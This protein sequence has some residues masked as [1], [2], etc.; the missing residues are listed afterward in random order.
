MSS[1]EL[2]FK[3]MVS[4]SANEVENF[5]DFAEDRAIIWAANEIKKFATALERI[6]ALDCV[7]GVGCVVNDKCECP[8]CIAADALKARAAGGGGDD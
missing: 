1:A 7:Y 5:N 3:E 2:K 8:S 4:A 6:A